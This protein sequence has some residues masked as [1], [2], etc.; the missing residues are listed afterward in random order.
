VSLLA[1]RPC[2]L[3][4]EGVAAVRSQTVDRLQTCSLLDKDVP[5]SAVA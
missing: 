3:L 2:T 5:T 4:Y 1:S